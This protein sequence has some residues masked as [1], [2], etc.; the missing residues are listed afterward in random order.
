MIFR[1]VAGSKEICR[2][3]WCLD[4]TPS[5]LLRTGKLGVWSMEYGVWSMEY[6]VWSME[7]G[8]WKIIIPN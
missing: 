8:V 3:D 4:A 5:L 1:G 6:G 7:Y 2:K